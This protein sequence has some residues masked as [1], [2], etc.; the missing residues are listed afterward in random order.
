MTP[1]NLIATGY[2]LLHFPLSM[3]LRLAS[4][5]TATE[6]IYSP[7]VPTGRLW[8][9]EHVAVEDETSNFTEFRLALAGRGEDVLLLEQE[10]PLAARLY[11]HD[12]PLYLTENTR[13]K[14]TLTGTTSADRLAV[15][16]NG[17]EL[18]QKGG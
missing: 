15:H 17:F 11:W 16:L 10:A 12:R 9:V 1:D 5:G 2:W 6:T 7:Y 3:T 13:L 14:V 4:T 18:R 8:V